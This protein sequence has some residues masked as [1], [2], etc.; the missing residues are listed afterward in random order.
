MASEN[1]PIAMSDICRNFAH[2]ADRTFAER[3]QAY[4]DANPDI[5]PSRLALDAGLDNSTVR[6]LLAGK[7]KNPRIDTA[8]RICAA[9][10]T[11]LEA[12]MG[13]EGD[14][15]RREI[16]SLYAQLSDDER[17]MLLAAAR[18]LADQRRGD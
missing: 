3:L 2:M 5:T 13:L 9:L 16:L 11:T 15:S 14:Q 17:R 8:I 6:Q 18:G 4:L 12:F 10:G 1:F 7:A